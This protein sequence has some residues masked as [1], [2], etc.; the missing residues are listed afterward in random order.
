MSPDSRGTTGTEMN[1]SIVLDSE[2]RR[3]HA[4]KV[5]SLLKLDRPKV[6]TV[7]DYH[8]QRSN[9]QNRRLW[10]LH[11]LAAEVT[12]Y[13]A[14]EMHEHSLCKHFGFAEK[15]VTDL[16]TGEIT[17]KRIPNKRSSVRDT[18][19]FSAYMEATE[20]WYISEFNVWLDQ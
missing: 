7:E 1:Q 2:P 13:S 10:K 3:E 8:P 11:S 4:L 16:F 9:S 14:E 19:E 5:L 17:I 6:V 15:E 18:K 20:A 12:G